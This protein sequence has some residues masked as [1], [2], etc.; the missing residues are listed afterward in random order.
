M[1]KYEPLNQFLSRLQA[2]YWRPTFLE[3]E[4]ILE[5]KLPAAAR[6]SAGWWEKDSGA[7][8][9]AHAWVD[10]G[11]KVESVDVE[12]ERVTFTRAE[13]AA[14]ETAPAHETLAQ[15]LRDRAE[16]LGDFADDRRRRA[17]ETVKEHPFA[18]S[19]ASAGVAF[20]AGIGL[21]YLLYR[22]LSGPAA[23][24]ASTTEDRA[25]H[26]LAALT[27]GVHDLAEAVGDRLRHLRG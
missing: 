5:F 10:A 16:A 21:G 17:V 1:S 18:V 7:S 11:W 26:A 3:L 25:R 8:R 22:A 24:A 20:A 15:R 13:G 4:R 9:H 2:D 6:K 27:E 19:G 14:A 12:K 23:S